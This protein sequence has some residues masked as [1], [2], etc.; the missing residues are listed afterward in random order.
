[1][2]D[3]GFYI[4]TAAQEEGGEEEKEILTQVWG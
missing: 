2:G 4:D 3:V 1:M